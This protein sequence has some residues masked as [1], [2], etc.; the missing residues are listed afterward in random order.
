MSESFIQLPSDSVGKS[1]RTQLNSGVHQEVHTL[2]DPDGTLVS[3]SLIVRPFGTWG[4]NAGISGT[5]TLTGGK[6]VLKIT[7]VAAEAAASF[8][9]NGGDVVT[10]PYGATDKV[11][12]DITIEPRGNLV[13][14][15]IIFT[16]T[17]AYFV[18]WVV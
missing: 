15:V 1:I 17:K 11:S 7:A 5:L 8:T 4:Y 18:E 9:I 10:L 2:A 12:S 16:G 3:S 14:P 6:K 13:N